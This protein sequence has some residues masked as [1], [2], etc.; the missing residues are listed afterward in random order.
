MTDAQVTS[1]D[2]L[3]RF[4]AE[5]TRADAEGLLLFRVI[6]DLLVKNEIDEGTEFEFSCV[7]VWT[8]KSLVKDND[9]ETNDVGVEKELEESEGRTDNIVLLLEIISQLLSVLN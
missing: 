5:P 2:E 4:I 3:D 1:D 6:F 8:R 9:V 7:L